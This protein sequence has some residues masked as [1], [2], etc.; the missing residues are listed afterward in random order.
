[1]QQRKYH[2]NLSMV[3][4]L[5][6]L[7]VG[8]VCLFII[9]FLL[10]NPIADDGKIDPRTEFIITMEWEDESIVDMDLWVQ[11]PSNKSIGYMQKEG[12]YMSLDRDDLGVSNDTYFINGQYV[13]VKRNIE[14]VKINAIQE[15]EYVINTHYFSNGGRPTTAAGKPATSAPITE[16]V[17]A[18]ITVIKMEPY[19]IIYTGT[20]TSTLK[21]EKTAVSFV[22]TSRGS[23]RDLRTD[24]NMPIRNKVA[25]P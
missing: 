16:P 13:T 22:I 5:F 2:S 6:N 11:G 18:K 17:T 9:A 24:I 7:L 8:F 20:T 10:I 1:M 12:G 25:T 14:T 3:D 23:I 4:M 19:R 21:Q 15:G